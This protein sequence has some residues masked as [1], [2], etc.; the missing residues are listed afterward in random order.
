MELLGGTEEPNGFDRSAAV[1]KFKLY[2]KDLEEKT[3]QEF[4]TDT[5]GEVQDASFHSQV[6]FYNPYAWLKFSSYGNMVCLFETEDGLDKS[7]RSIILELLDEHGYKYV[8]QE[9]VELEY[10]GDNPGVSGFR[11]WSYRFFDWI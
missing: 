2:V 8:P 5:G 10:D 11:D 3:G 4:N 6:Y 1:A 7:L 9:Y